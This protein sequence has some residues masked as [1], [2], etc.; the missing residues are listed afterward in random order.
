MQEKNS[1]TYKGTAVPSTES[2]PLTF[3]CIN[4]TKNDSNQR[5]TDLLAMT[6]TTNALIVKHKL[7]HDITNKQLHEFTFQ[8]V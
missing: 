3:E 6:T 7:F 8:T 5:E 2:F 1:S 4:D